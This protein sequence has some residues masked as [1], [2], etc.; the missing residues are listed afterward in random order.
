LRRKLFF[1]LGDRC[2]HLFVDFGPNARGTEKDLI[3]SL[4]DKGV[5]EGKTTNNAIAADEVEG[6]AQVA[7]EE[8]GEDEIAEARSGVR[9]RTEI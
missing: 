8:Q 1:Y 5:C 6:F 3:S 9:Q 4:A 2:C 7:E